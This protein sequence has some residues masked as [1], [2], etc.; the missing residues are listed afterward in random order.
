MTNKELRRLSR[1]DLLEMLLDVSKENEKLREE[2]EQLQAKLN[3]RTIVI[4][5]CG[6]LAEAAL[7]LNG[8]FQAAQAACE[9]Y[10]QNFT[11]RCQNG[12]PVETSAN[13]SDNKDETPAEEKSEG[14]EALI[15]ELKSRRESK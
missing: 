1:R 12:Q 11:A 14:R 6:S 15:Q 7:Q 4:E 10:I 5:N 3:D 2:V 13:D 8:V 9:Q